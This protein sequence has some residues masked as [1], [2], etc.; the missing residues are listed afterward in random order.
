MLRTPLVLITLAFLGCSHRPG[1]GDAGPESD[2]GADAGTDGGV[3]AG[4]D[5]GL[6]Q[7]LAHAHN[8]YR[9]V[10][11]LLDALEQGFTSVEA[12]VFLRDGGIIVSHD[13]KDIAGELGALYLQPLAERVQA[14]GSVYGDGG[15]FYLW[16]DLKEST[17][18]LQDALAARLS[19]ESDLTTFE[20]DG[21]VTLRPVTVILTGNGVAKKAL[22]ARPGPRPFIRDDVL[23]VGDP[24]ADNR[25]GY[26]AISYLNR[27]GWDGKG[28]IPE[29]D[30]NI[31]QG[32]IE[33]AHRTGR[34]I[35]IYDSPD[36]VPYWTVAQELG[37]DFINADDL[38]GLSAFLA[39]P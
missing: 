28:T 7:S 26:Y 1:G 34:K 9:H 31:L 25:W 36:T 39:Q 21:G 10:R 3:N 35:R 4:R 30:R 37:L 11:P 13:A 18:A 33:A 38:A 14:T 16:I 32:L 22:V 15:V 17:Q 6:R 12:D 27:I 29:A 5:A 20:D 2:A 23:A 8:D 19:Q 24:P